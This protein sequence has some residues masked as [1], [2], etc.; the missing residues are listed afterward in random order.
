MGEIEGRPLP[1]ELQGNY[2]ILSSAFY[3]G[4]SCLLALNSAANRVLRLPLSSTSGVVRV[5]ASF[6][7]VVAL[8]LS[9]PSAGHVRRLHSGKPTRSFGPP[10]PPP[11]CR[12]TIML[13]A[14]WAIAP[15]ISLASVRRLA[16]PCDLPGL[17]RSR[18][19]LVPRSRCKSRWPSSIW[20]VLLS[21]LRL[22]P[23]SLLPLALV[24]ARA[25]WVGSCRLASFLARKAQLALV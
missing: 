10:S 4:G 11:S 12:R 6:S 18:L 8:V 2:I 19:C 21:R 24:P 7:P 9:T 1:R 16:F 23:S 15:P 22:G 17:D 5:R 14:G 20:A 25:L 3:F 13:G